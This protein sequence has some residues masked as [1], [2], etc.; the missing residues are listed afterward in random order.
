[1][2][3]YSGAEGMLPPAVKNL[4][5][6]NFTLFILEFTP[7]GVSVIEHLGVS[8]E[9]VFLQGKFWQIFTYMFLHDPSNI[10]HIL[11]NMFLLWMF[12]K[13]LEWEWGTK[14]FLKFY[15][16]SGM[17]GGLTQ[18]LYA[19]LGLTI[20]ASGAVYGIFA[21]YLVY[22]PNRIIY[23]NLIFPVKVKYLIG[24]YVIMNMLGLVGSNVAIA[25]HL[26][27][28]AAGY[29]YLR[30]WFLYYKAK[31]FL[32]KSISN[33]SSTSKTNMS[34]TKGGSENTKVDY[35]RKRIDELLDKINKVGY[36]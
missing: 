34:Y 11:M 4:L 30:F 8:F 15:F 28:F 22:W 19:P 10:W 18:I 36:P 31:S 1:M 33:P 2:N 26:G 16:I 3:R 12:G 24:F 29:L 13:D 35:Y 21:A 25:A 5:L 32:N 6:A 27:G 17:V 14:K 9:G 20:G 7:F 23:L